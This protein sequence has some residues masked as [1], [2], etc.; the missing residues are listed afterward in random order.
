MYLS[1]HPPP[2]TH[3]QVKIAVQVSNLVHS[4]FRIL[5]L[6]KVRTSSLSSYLPLNCQPPSHVKVGTT[7]NQGGNLRVRSAL[8]MGQAL[9]VLS[10]GRQDRAAIVLPTVWGHHRLRAMCLIS[11]SWGVV[12]QSSALGVRLWGHAFQG[13]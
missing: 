7:E 13:E 12:G 10:S 4:H 8:P 11:Q 3:I 9:G 5:G 6:W 1:L 2:H